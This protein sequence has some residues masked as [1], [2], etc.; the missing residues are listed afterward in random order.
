[1]RFVIP[2]V[3]AAVVAIAAPAA[4]AS[5]TPVSPVATMPARIAEIVLRGAHS[6]ADELRVLAL[7]QLAHPSREALLRRSLPVRP[8]PGEVTSQ[9]G[10]RK[11]PMRS[12]RGRR[13]ERHA[14]L[15]LDAKMGTPVAAAGAGVIVRA[16]HEGGYGRMVVI[17]HGNGVETRYAHLSRIVVRRGQQVFAGQLLGKAGATGRATGVH[18]HFE[19]RVTGRPLDPA[20]IVAAQAP[21]VPV[22]PVAG[23]GVAA[24]V[25]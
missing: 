15:D 2:L 10:M 11:D 1:M 5:V 20:E 3:L 6:Q 8:V 12:G 19:I 18:L 9:F 16:G 24:A 23:V 7:V 4:G 17:D 21:A 22:T 14:G 25:W 13:R